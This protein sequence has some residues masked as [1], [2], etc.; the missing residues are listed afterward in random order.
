MTVEVVRHAE[1]VS[2]SPD[3]TFFK[4]AKRF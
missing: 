4:H 2:A 1:L 3:K